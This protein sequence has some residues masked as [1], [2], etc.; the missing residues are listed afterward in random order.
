MTG[1]PNVLYIHSHDTGRHVQPYG[2]PVE[3]PSLQRLAEEGMLFRQAFAAASS[4][5]ASRASL[6]TGTAAHTNGMLGLAHRGWSLHDYRWHVVH[7]LRAAGYATALVGEQHVSKRPE[8]LGYD[9]VLETRSAS[10]GDVASAAVAGLRTIVRPFFLSVGFR[11]THRPFAPPDA[12]DTRYV[13]PPPNLPDTPE[14]RADFAAFRA[15]A[16]SLDRGMGTVFAAL[17]AEELTETTLVI[18]TTDHGIPFPGWKSTLS[19]RGLG[20]LLVLRGPRFP[21]GVVSDALVSQIDLFPTVCDVLELEPPPRVQGRSLLPLASGADEVR[22]AVFGEGTYH[23]AYEPQRTVRTRGWRYVRR[24]G[25]RLLPVPANT[26][27]GPSKDVW[28]RAGGLEHPLDREQLYDVT[29]DP[30]ELVNRID[31][32]ACAKILSDL[33]ARLERWMQETD[34]PLL[35]G[36]VEPPPGAEYNL[37]DQLSASEPT[38]RA[39]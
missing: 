20:V 30:E 13:R 31:D 10:A 37:P 3:T 15:S 35:A 14:T 2:Y 7:T 33:R 32:P 25:E 24:Y 27:D 28:V 19:D 12:G 18:C 1:R 22:D 16:L 8:E 21:A 29:L 23:A 6:L 26:D 11:E 4:C 36:P 5:S 9:H 38:R 34:D 17:D 39:R